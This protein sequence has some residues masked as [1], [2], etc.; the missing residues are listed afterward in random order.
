MNNI[1]LGTIN[2][3]GDGKVILLAAIN[4]QLGTTHTLD[5]FDFGIP[6][7]V[8][9]P[10]PTHNSR[11]AFGPKLGTG[12]YGVR[13][14]YYNRIQAADLG[15]IIVPYDGE[16]YVTEILGKI[17][18]KYG[19]YITAADVYDAVI[20]A[21]AEG[22][23]QA[24]VAL[25]FRPES[26]IFT[27]GTTATIGQNDPT[28]DTLPTLPFEAYHTLV[29]NQTQ[30]FTL[31][32]VEQ[33]LLEP[34]SLSVDNDRV[35]QHTGL[36]AEDLYAGN[37]NAHNRLRMTRAQYQTQGKNVPFVGM[38][39]DPATHRVMAVGP[40]GDVYRANVDGTA[41]EF[42][43]NALGFDNPTAAQITGAY[44]TP[45]VK[46][47]V[48]GADGVAYFLAKGADNV[49][50]IYSTAT[51]QTVWTVLGM[52]VTRMISL[53]AASWPTLEVMDACHV[54]GKFYLVIRSPEVYEAHV[55]KGIHTPSL[56][57]LNTVSNTVDYFPLGDTTVTYSGIALN[58][59]H[60]EARW[61]IATPPVATAT[62]VDVVALVPS[63][64]NDNTYAVF[65][66]HVA[67]AEYNATALP[68]TYLGGAQALRSEMGV[69]AYQLPL[70]D[71]QAEVAGVP[72][73]DHYLD[74]V[75]II[76]P[77]EVSDLNRYFLKTG[78]RTQQNFLTYGA[79]VLTSVATR[80]ART[81]WFE[82]AITLSSSQKPE[83]VTLQCLGL[84]NHVLFQNATALHRLRFR[85][86][87]GTYQ[88][89]AELDSSVV[90]AAHT[91]YAHVCKYGAGIFVPTTVID[92]PTDVAVLTVDQDFE[93]VLPVIGYSFL[94][95]A[96]GGAYEWH[97]G[98]AENTLL[99]KRAP[100]RNYAFMGT[101][102]C[103]VASEGNTLLYWS[104]MG[105]GVFKSTDA[106]H[107]WN[108]YNAAPA[109]YKQERVASGSLNI[110]GSANL[111]L[112]PEHFKE[113]TL[114]NGKLLVETQFSDTAKVYDINAGTVNTV[115][116][117]SD[118]M[119]FAVDAYAGQNHYTVSD[120]QT[121]FGLNT[122]SSFSPRV[123][124]AW[125]SDANNAYET[126][127]AYTTAVDAPL[128]T[129]V[130]QDNYMF[131]VP[132]T[133]VDF[134]RDVR[135]LGYRHWTLVNDAEVWNLHFTNKVAPEKTIGLFGSTNVLLDQFKPEVSFH[136]WDF[137]DVGQSYMP[138]VFY[139][140]K[141]VV[142]LERLDVNSEFA[143]TQFILNI[144]GDNGQALTPV[145][146]HTANRRDYLFAQKGNGIFRLV[147]TWDGIARISTLVLQRIF[148][149]TA[150]SL[151]NLTFLSGCKV[152]VAARNAP[153]EVLLPDALPIDTVIGW[154]CTGSTRVDRFADGAGGYYETTTI[155]SFD[156]GYV[157]PSVPGQPSGF[158]GGTP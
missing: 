73:T 34:F 56:E 55:S 42:L 52:S 72:V 91:G 19:I 28:G 1:Y 44:T 79:K 102:P 140:N 26:I 100:S 74:V 111:T 51:S 108:E 94:A 85:Q 65:Y 130:N 115:K 93:A 88:F 101:A 144:P 97:T 117:L 25:E 105:N 155:N 103:L 47:V 29:F 92:S 154:Y 15:Q 18:S 135:Y 148:A 106:G 38:W 89:S 8:D 116:T 40:L 132:G 129:K 62:Q 152:G 33:V 50:R 95:Q 87:V 9:V 114:V 27:S 36:I 31:D 82:S 151:M 133:L 23:T 60:P 109:F 48:Q 30:E 158:G 141:R 66:R 96:V 69:S 125:D 138:Y 10:T 77:T 128:A 156:C 7:A 83:S 71:V 157:N 84:R 134:S 21:P 67:G 146:M 12:Y 20:P 37:T 22:V 14:I 149:L 32:G 122:L 61:V 112:R 127:G 70:T 90:L 78:T 143:A 121:G 63:L 6:S 16:M 57:V 124:M 58:G 46:A 43:A 3:G 39:T 24:T 64:R 81:P 17:N 99:A 76:A 126:I 136:L 11:V 98:T 145:R 107:S 137:E 75:E 35:R 139:G 119:L 142:L 54:G 131:Q 4:A 41:W 147:Y 123:V 49:P 120:K 104:P 59:S 13:T 68:H 80:D 5:D 118:S 153:A 45:L 113:S 86:A 150:A 110:M 53:K 2:A